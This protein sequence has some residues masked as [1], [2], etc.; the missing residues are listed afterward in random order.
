MR[1]LFSGK[2]WIILLA[3]VSLTGL[4]L[5]ASGLSGMKFGQPTLGGFENIFGA[6]GI[7]SK[8]TPT[9]SWLRYMIMGMFIVLFLVMLGPIRP[10]TSRN[11]V[12]QLVRF[13]IFTLVLALVMGR[14]AE[15]S[16]LFRPDDASQNPASAASNANPETFTAPSVSEQWEYWITSAIVIVLGVV[17]IVVFN[18]LVDRW[19]QPKSSLDEFA[20]IARTTLDDLSNTK[21]SRNAI[22]RC[23]TRMNAVVNKNR[24]IAREAAMTPSEFARHLENAGLPGDAVQDLTRVFERVRYGG[25]SASPDEIKEAKHCLTSIVKSCEIQK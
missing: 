10:Q 24:G 16:P 8:N 13:S 7:A 1:S 11:M 23:Y 18:R 15:S 2:N 6:G 14:I 12:M 20:N 19:F 17:A 22:I 4:I 3:L 21:E 25:Q 5:L 9:A